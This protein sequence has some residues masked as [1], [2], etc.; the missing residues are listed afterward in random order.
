MESRDALDLSKIAFENMQFV[1]ENATDGMIILDR[2]GVFVSVNRAVENATGFSRKDLIG[3]KFFETPLLTLK[4]K[5]VAVEKFLLRK[6]GQGVLPYEVQAQTKNGV[7][8]FYEIN[9]TLIEK[10][11]AVLGEHVVLRDLTERKKIEGELRLAS[12]KL[13]ELISTVTHDLQYDSAALKEMV[14]KIE[15][16]PHTIDRQ[17]VQSALAKATEIEKTVS[18]LA[19]QNRI[20]HPNE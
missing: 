1:F 3:K 20:R 13:A 16:N 2:D 15:K 19:R 11:G 18:R 8:V 17:T 5:A 14:S 10:N 6:A 7:V 4:S 12:Q 9:A